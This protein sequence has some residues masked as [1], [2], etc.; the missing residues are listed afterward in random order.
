M[1]PP[2]LTIDLLRHGE[3]DTDSNRVYGATDV[4]LSSKGKVQLLAASN[5]IC[6]EPLTHLTSS[7]KQRCSW[8]PKN[9]SIPITATFEIGFSEM[10]FGD[11]EGQ[12]ISGLLAQK[13]SFQPNLNQLNPPNG[14][15]FEN[16]SE[17][18]LTTWDKYTKNH[19]TQGGHHLMISHGGVMRVILGKIL[20]I[21]D[22]QLS[23]LYI[24][25]ASWSRITL[26]EGEEPMLWF[27]NQH[28]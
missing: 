15:S 12:E 8:L 22:E 20:H 2:I 16:F 21:P 26:V 4:P 9:L 1:T 17:R 27:M 5:I 18:V 6:E 23:R 19:I 7:P 13:N 3:T 11:W 24:P 10:D 28:A 14:E 25:H